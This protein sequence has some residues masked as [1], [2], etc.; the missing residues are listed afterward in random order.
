MRQASSHDLLTPVNATY[1]LAWP[2]RHPNTAEKQ[3]VQAL[4]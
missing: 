3:G 2:P 4:S 1:Q